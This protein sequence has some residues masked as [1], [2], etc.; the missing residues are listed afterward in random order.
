[1]ATTENGNG[2]FAQNFEPLI[3]IPNPQIKRKKVNGAVTSLIYRNGH[4]LI[5]TDACEIYL[6]DVETFEMNLKI[7]CNTSAIND[8]AFPE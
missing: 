8:I 4:A 3:L 1:M 2:N 6:L 5:A 7:T